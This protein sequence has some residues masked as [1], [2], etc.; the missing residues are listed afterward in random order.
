MTG[1]TEKL[2]MCQMFMCLFRPPENSHRSLPRRAIA[3]K[4]ANLQLQ[5]EGLASS[6]RLVRPTLRREAA[7]DARF[8][9]LRLSELQD[10]SKFE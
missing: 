10:H 4:F 1:V 8:Q 7:T 6:P 9:A 5:G 3:E 2:F